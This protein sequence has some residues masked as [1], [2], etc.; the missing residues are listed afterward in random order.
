MSLY[1]FT[2]KLIKNLEKTK[3]KYEIYI[4]ENDTIVAYTKDK[5]LLYKNY[6]EENLK[7]FVL[8]NQDV[9]INNFFWNYNYCNQSNI[10]TLEKTDV[11]TDLEIYNMGKLI[12]EIYMTEILANCF[13][14][15]KNY[16]K[17]LETI[18]IEKDVF[19]KFLINLNSK[20]PLTEGYLELIIKV[21]SQQYYKI[22]II[23]FDEIDDIIKFLFQKGDRFTLEENKVIF[24]NIQVK[25]INSA[26]IFIT[27]NSSLNQFDKLKNIDYMILNQ[28]KMIGEIKHQIISHKNRENFLSFN[29]LN[30]DIEKENI[31]IYKDVVN[32]FINTGGSLDINIPDDKLLNDELKQKIMF[33]NNLL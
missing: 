13:S 4:P 6:T 23:D 16:K 27:K 17:Y 15:M 3:F 31:N 5:K 10:S 19:A 2:E 25:N 32:N 9:K 7:Y 12:L 11:L 30:M 21:F 18:N 29:L 1:L 33:T 24:E 22:D 28:H 26:S 14:Y 20:L 8:I